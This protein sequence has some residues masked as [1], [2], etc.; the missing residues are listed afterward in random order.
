M[1]QTSE[2]QMNF[3]A[4][5]LGFVFPGAG[6]LYLRQTRR[7]V[8]ASIGVLGL[9][10]GGLLIGGIDVVDR[11]EDKWW[12]LG[13]ALVGPMTFAVDY[14][15]Q[16]RLKAYPLD[17]AEVAS[18]RIRADR[19]AALPRRSLMPG[20]KRMVGEVQTIAPTRETDAQGRPTERV[21]VGQT[22]KIAYVAPAGP[23]E[24]P[25]N[26]KSIG[27]MNELG[28]LSVTIAGMLNFIIMLDALFPA[29]IP[30]RKGAAPVAGGRP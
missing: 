13:Q 4:G 17:P 27:R 3:T 5:L 23:G 2:D 10:L 24:G 25:P 1:P 6:H 14:Y 22:L 26:T 16:N 19:L 30:T 18:G 29:L 11:K 12:F 9:F 28:M 7:G 8:L 15:H 21:A 20:E